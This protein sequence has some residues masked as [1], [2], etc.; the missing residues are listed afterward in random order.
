V[1]AVTTTPS[2]ITSARQRP[3]RPASRP[4]RA[5]TSRRRRSAAIDQGIQCVRAGSLLAAS[6]PASDNPLDFNHPACTRTGST[7]SNSF[8]LPT[9]RVD[10]GAAST[11]GSNALSRFPAG[12]ARLGGD[13]RATLDH[14]RTPLP[15]LPDAVHRHEQAPDL[16]LTSHSERRFPERALREHTVREPRDWGREWGSLSN[17]L[18]P[19][20]SRTGRG[21]LVRLCRPTSSNIAPTNTPPETRSLM[22]HW[23]TCSRE[24][25]RRGITTP[26]SLRP[27]GIRSC[28]MEI[29][30]A[31]MALRAGLGL[32]QQNA[33]RVP[34]PAR[35]GPGARAAL[36]ASFSVRWRN[37]EAP[38]GALG[39][40]TSGRLKPNSSTTHPSRF[41][42]ART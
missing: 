1:L 33:N 25:L 24:H 3:A 41:W 12:P 23:R 38:A 40:W 29:R 31:R 17:E 35:R 39:R 37:Y 2:S 20:S 21:R 16:S 14:L 15:P 19:S 26:W 5:T 34:R 27:R 10:G 28:C 32:Y 22:A 8:S 13:R 9:P 4:R 36:N 11:T 18:F 6:T 7:L 42:A 30:L